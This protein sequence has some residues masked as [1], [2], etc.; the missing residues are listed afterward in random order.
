M[1]CGLRKLTVVSFAER[2]N[3][4]FLGRELANLRMTA[5]AFGCGL[6]QTAMP[7]RRASSL[8]RAVH[9]VRTGETLKE[10]REARGLSF[11]DVPS[12]ALRVRREAM[13]HTSR[14]EASYHRW[15]PMCVCSPPPP[16]PLPDLAIHDSCLVHCVGTPLN[17]AGLQLSKHLNVFF[18]PSF[19]QSA[20]YWFAS[21][22]PPVEEQSRGCHKAS[23]ACQTWA[24]HRAVAL[25]TPP[26]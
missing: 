15:P 23:R 24:K 13:L 19:P 11:L 1:Y 21:P 8:P 7:H 12:P 18:S 14:R 20:C 25:P 22:Q 26:V 17:C 6:Q 3:P 9:Q 16:P 4:Y 10:W 5:V 2:L